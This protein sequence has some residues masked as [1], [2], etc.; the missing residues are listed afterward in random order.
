MTILLGTIK[1]ASRHLGDAASW[2]FGV[3]V[4]SASR[5]GYRRYFKPQWSR[6]AR[7]EV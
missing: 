6:G 3:G 1:R 2:M 5:V 7:R 4:R